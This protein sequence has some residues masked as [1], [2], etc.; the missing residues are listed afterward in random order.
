V[1]AFD[2]QKAASAVLNPPADCIYLVLLEVF[3]ARVVSIRHRKRIAQF[4][5]SKRAKREKNEPEK[6]YSVLDV[7][8]MSILQPAE[9]PFV[10][11]L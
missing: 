9:N 6:H 11:R 3:I 1:L 2:F 10:E 4:V 7:P 8:K 5:H